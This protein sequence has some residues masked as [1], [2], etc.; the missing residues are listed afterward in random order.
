MR[1]PIQDLDIN[2]RGTLVLL[3]ALKSGNRAG[4]VIFAG[5]RGEYGASVKLPVGEDHPTNPKGI[6]AVTNLTAE[7]MV[8]VYDDIFGIRGTSL[9]ITNT[10]GPRHQ[11][12]HDEYGVFNWFIRKALD[13]EMI[14]VFGDG[15]ILRDFL[16]VEDLVECL[17]TVASTDAAYGEVFNVGTGVPISFHDLARRISEVVGSG[18]VSFTDFTRERKEVE[19]GDYYADISKIKRATGWTPK[20]SLEEGIRRTADFYRMHQKEYWD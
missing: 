11:M 13:D 20:T 10:F 8:L 15:T 6:Y 3:E 9:R 7:K 18:K 5:T 4:R 2:C 19:P 16:Y 14:P 12:A 17:L 1:N